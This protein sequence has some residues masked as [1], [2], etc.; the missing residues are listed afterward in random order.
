MFVS[1]VGFL[2]HNICFVYLGKHKMKNEL[3][4]FKKKTKW[5]AFVRKKN[6]RQ[7][8]IIL[9]SCFFNEITNEVKIK[10]NRLHPLGS[11]N[12]SSNLAIIFGISKKY[13]ESFGIFQNTWY[14]INANHL[15]HKSILSSFLGIIRKHIIPVNKFNTHNC[16]IQSLYHVFIQM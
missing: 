3:K 4:L 15:N 12:P 16:C 2:F 14:I 11:R 8:T 7:Q 5:K 9:S 6:T 1:N 13:T 10:T